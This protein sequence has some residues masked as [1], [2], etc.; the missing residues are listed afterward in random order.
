MVT[1]PAWRE[2]KWSADGH[3]YVHR[4]YDASVGLDCACGKTTEIT[5]DHQDNGQPHECQS[6]GRQYRLIVRL[7]TLD[8]DGS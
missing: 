6:C 4:W 1:E 2:A 3:D 5:L 8:P 7:E